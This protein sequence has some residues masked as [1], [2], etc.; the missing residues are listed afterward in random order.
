M[1]RRGRDYVRKHFNRRDHG[2]LFTSVLRARV[3]RTQRSWS[4]RYACALTESDVCCADG[5]AA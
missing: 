2:E 4:F 3:D 1:G 5:C